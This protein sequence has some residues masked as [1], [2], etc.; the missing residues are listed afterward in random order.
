MSLRYLVNRN[1]SLMMQPSSTAP[2][3]VL[4]EMSGCFLP[5]QWS[6]I[7]TQ[8]RFPESSGDSVQP[9]VVDNNILEQ[10]SN[11]SPLPYLPLTYNHPSLSNV[12]TQPLASG[13][14]T[15]YWTTRPDDQQRPQ[16]QE[17]R[18]KREQV[19]SNMPTL[20]SYQDVLRYQ[21]PTTI[22]ETYAMPAASDFVIK[23]YRLVSLVAVQPHNCHSSHQSAVCWRMRLCLTSFAGVPRAI[24]LLSET[25]RNSRQKYSRPSSGIPILPVLC[26][27]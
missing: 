1:M 11:Q 10:S 15:R 9:H 20:Q 13:S 7:Q 2:L 24:S 21:L 26:V 16:S 12:S 6:S 4:A 17:L 19:D 22:T 8:A 14:S 3:R 27:S 18:P 25:S 23:L 5:Q